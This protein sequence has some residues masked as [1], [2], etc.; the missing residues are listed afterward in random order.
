MLDGESR[1]GVFIGTVMNTVVMFK[2]QERLF[3]LST[4]SFQKLNTNFSDGFMKVPKAK[5]GHCVNIVSRTNF[6]TIF[7][8]EDL[9]TLLKLAKEQYKR[10][11]IHS[12]S[13]HITI[14]G[15]MKNTYGLDC[16]FELFFSEVWLIICTKN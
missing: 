3:L 5:W 10:N 11:V 12:F 7:C 15:K 2:Q 8:M 13:S 9:V 6:L 16:I 4:S 1:E 14:E